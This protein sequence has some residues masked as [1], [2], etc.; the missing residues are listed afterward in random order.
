MSRAKHAGMTLV[1]LL[2]AM[3]IGVGVVFAVST[4]LV[5]GEN[6]KRTTTS[7]NDAVQ[8]G[9]YAVYALDRALR[10]AGSA[11]AQS[12]Y[13]VDVGVLGCRLNAGTFLPRA[14]AF[15]APFATRFLPGATS[16]LRVAPVLIAAGQ[17]DSAASDVLV[18][19]GGSGAAGGVSRSV[20]GVGG[21]NSLVLES[22]VGFQQYDLALVSQNATP[23]CLLEEATNNISSSTLT[24]INN[25]TYPYYTA[26]TVTTLATLASSLNSAVTPLGNAAVNSVSFQLFGVGPNFTLYSYDLLQNQLRV[27]KTGGDTSQAIADGVIQMNAIY[28]VATAPPSVFNNWANP[29]VAPY[30]IASVMNTPNTQKSI[31]SVRV[32]LV[33]RGEYYD[34]KPVSPAQLT[35]FNGLKD[36]NGVSLAKNVPIAL[37][38]RN[39]RYRVFEF[40]V[41]LRD[42]ILLAG[43]P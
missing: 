41:P 33:V 11:I 27:Q 8:T 38:D 32:A 29:T 42:M 2:V 19:M 21:A 22:T 7:T 43:G 35:I 16:T 17:S 10:G 15:P 20:N 30:D 24:L 34:K 13:G 37:Q 31:I 12:A 18:V 9:A 14:G 6:H 3:A 5:A 36:G 4:L 39:Y 40:T 25:A 28:G 26:G 23:D 1:E